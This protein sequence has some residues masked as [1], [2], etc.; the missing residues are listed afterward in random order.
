MRKALDK[1]K[2]HW[3][4]L[5]ILTTYVAIC[6]F[7]TWVFDKYGPNIA[8]MWVAVIIA[9]IAAIVALESLRA[10]TKSLKLTQD[11]LKLTRATTRPFLNVS[12]P[13]TILFQSELRLVICN[14]GA[15]PADKVEILCTLRTIENEV[16]IKEYELPAWNKAPSIYFPGDEV[17]PIYRWSPADYDFADDSTRGKTLIRVTIDYRNR[18]TQETYTTTRIFMAKL[19]DIHGQYLLDP[20]PRYD[21][22]DEQQIN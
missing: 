8:L 16:V 15:L 21:S 1:I 6:L 20:I 13:N 18:L 10:I 5:T 17:G 7:L 19:S 14:T 3:K 12:M 2:H 9:A 11:S 4:I 22:W